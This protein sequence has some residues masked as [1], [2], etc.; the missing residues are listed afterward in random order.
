MSIEHPLTFPN[1]YLDLERYVGMDGTIV[2]HGV[3]FPVSTYSSTKFPL[4]FVLCLSQQ[5][6]IEAP[7]NFKN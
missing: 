1:D 5:S 3:S 2:F 7:L 6:S 4:L